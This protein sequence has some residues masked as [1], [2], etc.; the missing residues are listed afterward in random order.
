MQ[1][2]WLLQW[3]SILPRVLAFLLSLY[4]LWDG[5]ER[6]ATDETT[7]SD[8]IQTIDV[9]Y[10]GVDLVVSKKARRKNA[11]KTRLTQVE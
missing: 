10:Y 9:D 5:Y 11:K 7:D 1:R 3:N 6:G 4:V 2:Q 8:C